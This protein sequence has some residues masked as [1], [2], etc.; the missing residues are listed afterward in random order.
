MTNNNDMLLH[1]QRG[2]RDKML[3]RLRLRNT[4]VTKMN[5]QH[6]GV[7]IHYPDAGD[8]ANDMGGEGGGTYQ[9]DD[10]VNDYHAAMQQQADA[11]S[12]NKQN[13][14]PSVQQQPLVEQENQEG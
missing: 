9:R 1:K 11:T 8:D 5:M 4:I 3:L 14:L 7:V 12:Q 6:C 10:V 13:T 2:R